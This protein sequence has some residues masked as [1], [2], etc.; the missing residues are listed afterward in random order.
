MGTSIRLGKI[1]GIPIGINYSWIFV[2]LL[3]I[4][5]ISEQFGIAYPAWPIPQR[6][7]IAVLTTVLLF[8]SVLAHE[9]SHSLVAVRRHIPVHGITFFI[10]GGVSHLGHEAK[11][12]Q[13]E[14]LVAVVGPMASFLLALVFGLLWYFT[15]GLNNS[16]SA[17]VFT[18]FAINLSLGAFNMLPGFPLDGGRVLRSAVWGISGSY[19]LGTRV[20]ARSGQVLGGLMILGGGLWA[21]SGQFQGI[22][23]SLIGGFLIIVATASYRQERAR[24]SLKSYR[25]ADVM[26]TDWYLLPGETSLAS[27]LVTQGLAGREDFL[28][29]LVGRQMV[30]VITR[31]ILSQVPAATRPFRSLTQA[32]IPLSALPALSPEDA[33]FDVMERQD[34]ENLDRLV[35]QVNGAP[36]GFVT[37]EQIGRFIGNRR[38][39]RG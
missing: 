6:W 26:T 31:R 8:A 38:R 36:M 9:L 37:R 35:V 5:L 32:M 23:F 34:N 18:L 27:P 2:F 10:F 20:A 3:Y 30:G 29:V 4:F 21:V 24:E 13:T 1:W 11:R 19:W 28:G 17:I 15:R 16:M 22:W 39:S 12:P 7:T 25:V 14:F 33:I